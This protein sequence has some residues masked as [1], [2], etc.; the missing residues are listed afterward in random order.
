MIST[1]EIINALKLTIRG[2][3]GS[4]VRYCYRENQCIWYT[5]ISSIEIINALKLTI[6]FFWN[7]IKENHIHFPGIFFNFPVFFFKQNQRKSRYFLNTLH[8]MIEKKHITFDDGRWWWWWW[9][10]DDELKLWG[11]GSDSNEISCQRVKFL[12]GSIQP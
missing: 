3:C 7:K 5:L 6:R 10:G 4:G 1:I 11:V 2:V 8:L 12:I 9:W